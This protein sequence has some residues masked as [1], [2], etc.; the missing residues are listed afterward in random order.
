[1]VFTTRFAGGRAGAEHHQR[2]LSALLRDLRVTQKHSKPALPQP[3]PTR[4]QVRL[5]PGCVQAGQDAEREENHERRNGVETEPHSECRP[6][7]A[8][9]TTETKSA[10]K[11]T[12]TKSAFK[13]TE[14]KSA[15]KTTAVTDNGDDG[16]GFGARSAWLYV[17]Y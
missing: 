12:E 8:S 10:F 7:L 16:Q 5:D 1:M 14:T 6:S 13:T 4:R 3:G 17:T 15:F 11:T 9:R 2:L